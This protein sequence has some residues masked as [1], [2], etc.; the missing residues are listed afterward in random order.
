VYILP[1]CFFICCYALLIMTIVMQLFVCIVCDRNT[2]ELRYDPTNDNTPDGAQPMTM[3][4]RFV[5][6]YI[7]VKCFVHMFSSTL[8]VKVK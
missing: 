2:V 1:S 5:A 6:Y 4:K 8:K 7:C 3:D